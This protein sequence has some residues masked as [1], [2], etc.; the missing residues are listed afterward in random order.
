MQF[1]VVVL[2]SANLDHLIRVRDFPQPGE[3]VAAAGHQTALGGKGAN[4]ALAAARCGARVA[5]AGAVGDDDA[6]ASVLRLLR[7]DGIDTSRTATVPGPTGRA[8]VTVDQAGQNQI[9]VAAGANA[10][11]QPPASLPGAA[12][13]LV[14]LEI[15]AAAARA[16]MAGFRGTVVLNPAPSDQAAGLTGLAGVLVPNAVEL[17]RLAGS[18]R[19]PDSPADALALVRDL[20][21]D[22][23]VVVTLGSDGAL[24]AGPGGAAWQL[25]APRVS[26]VDTTG[27]GDAFCG[28]LA[29]ALAR[30]DTI[31]AAARRGVAAGAAAVTRPG[32][33][34]AMPDAAAVAALLP[35]VTAVPL[36][37][38]PL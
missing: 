35:G 15:P 17:A 18:S 28:A 3:T 14:Q 27:A 34:S 37:L 11:L 6:G 2:G 8:F 13:L 16:A 9:V 25:T 5:F 29:A 30:G 10:L 4:Q 23:A 26:V 33:G 1:D 21:H 31:T 22:G 32:A 12:V 19:V 38:G 36:D 20:R 7:G 24:V